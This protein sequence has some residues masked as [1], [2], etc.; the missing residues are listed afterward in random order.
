MNSEILFL[1]RFEFI[2]GRKRYCFQLIFSSIIVMFPLNGSEMAIS[3]I[4]STFFSGYEKSI[5]LEE[6]QYMRKR[7]NKLVSLLFYVEFYILF[8]VLQCWCLLYFYFP[9]DIQLY[10]F[11]LFY[12]WSMEI[13][14]IEDNLRSIGEPKVWRH[15][16]RTRGFFKRDI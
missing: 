5:N 13:S 1:T 11:L 15:L 12:Q 6:N 9:G 7:E 10:Y 14:E 3:I 4:S 2:K 8:F 16:C